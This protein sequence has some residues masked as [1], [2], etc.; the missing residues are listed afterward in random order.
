MA[1]LSRRRRHDST[2]QYARALP[3]VTDRNWQI[4]GA[5]DFRGSDAADILWRNTETGEN[6]IWVM[7]GSTVV[8]RVTIESLETNWY[9]R[10]MGDFN[11]DRMTDIAWSHSG[12][13]ET[14]LWLM[15][16]SVVQGEKS[17]GNL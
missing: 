11:G 14:K 16:G 17:L 2:P 4:L 5:S 10:G 7:E 12:T 6:M 15:N 8:E 1:L 9:F 3:S 13:G